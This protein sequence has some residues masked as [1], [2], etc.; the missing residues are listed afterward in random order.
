MNEEVSTPHVLATSAPP[1]LCPVQRSGGAVSRRCPWVNRM[2]LGK[3]MWMEELPLYISPALQLRT[4]V[5]D[6]G[7]AIAATELDVPGPEGRRKL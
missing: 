2:K 3:H 5:L 6:M 7:G 4:H 1:F